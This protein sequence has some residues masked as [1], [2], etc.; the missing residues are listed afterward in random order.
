MS[1]L[2]KDFPYSLRS[3]VYFWVENGCYEKADKGIEDS[4]IDAV[5]KIVNSGE[6]KKHNAGG[7]PANDDPVLR[8][9]EY[10]KYAYDIFKKTLN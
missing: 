3:A 10:S 5:T 7:Y 9:R 2:V 6:L 8:R 4:H 1:G